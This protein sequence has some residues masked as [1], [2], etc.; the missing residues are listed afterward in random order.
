[1]TPHTRHGR[2]QQAY[3]RKA[4]EDKFQ[5]QQA[6]LLARLAQLEAGAVAAAQHAPGAAAGVAAPNSSRKSSASKSSAGAGA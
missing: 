2:R 6:A 1:M 4:M 5:L 3:L